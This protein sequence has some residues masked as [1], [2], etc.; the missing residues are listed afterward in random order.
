MQVRE[1]V[2]FTH[3]MKSICLCYAD[4]QYLA[5]RLSKNLNKLSSRLKQLIE[6]YN[7]LPGVCA[8]DCLSWKDI[9]NLGF[10]HWYTNSF[11]SS[12]AYVPKKIQFDAIKHHHLVLRSEEEIQLLETEMKA[13]VSF[14]LKDWHELVSAVKKIRAMPSSLYNNGALQVVQMTRLRC[15]EMLHGLVASYSQYVE[16]EQLPND[17]FI[18][19]PSHIYHHSSGSNGRKI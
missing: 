15:E 2:F 5:S 9:T 16:I 17:E 3:G 4:G 14:Y 10:I 7:S 18:I 8:A 11:G 6:D 13:A 1:Y 19:V 12:E